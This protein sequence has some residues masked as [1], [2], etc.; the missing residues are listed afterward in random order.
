MNQKEK[1]E[2]ETLL[3]KM[4]EVRD[5]CRISKSKKLHAKHKL[6]QQKCVQ[7]YDFLVEIKTRKYRSFSNYDD[8]KQDGRLAL[9][10]AMGTYDKDKGDFIWWANQYIKTKVCREANRHSTIK[11]PMKHAK[12]VQPYKVSQLPIIIDGDPNAL[13]SIEGDEVKD[14]VQ[15][16]VDRLPTQQ[17]RIIKLY[18]EFN[19][20]RPHSISKICQEMEISRVNCIK[21]LNEAKQNLK[22]ELEGHVEL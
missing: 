3:H 9:I 16:A 10:L 15:M 17:A 21:L 2:A 13:Q 1:E 20:L 7:K 4:L 12:N 5:R 8:L 11:I 14:R 18:Y 22:Q 19:G 6:L